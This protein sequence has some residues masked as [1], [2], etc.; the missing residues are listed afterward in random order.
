[1]NHTLNALNF[2][3]NIIE[4][5]GNIRYEYILP[6]KQEVI[7]SN[8]KRFGKYDDWYEPKTPN[9][10]NTWEYPTYEAYENDIDEQI[11]DDVDS[12]QINM[13][14]WTQCTQDTIDWFK[15]RACEACFLNDVIVDVDETEKYCSHCGMSYYI[16]EHLRVKSKIQEEIL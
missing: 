14:R 10:K 4:E 11:E 8:L 3:I 6:K 15:D 9:S 16:P 13:D 12:Y 5:F 7:Y 2:G 1:M